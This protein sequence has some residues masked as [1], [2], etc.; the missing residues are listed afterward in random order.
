MMVIEC[1]S[2]F[3][4][5]FKMRVF[6]VRVKISRFSQTLYRN[7]TMYVFFFHSIFPTRTPFQVFTGRPHRLGVGAFDPNTPHYSCIHP[8][9]ALARVS[10]GVG[11]PHAARENPHQ[12]QRAEES[13]LSMFYKKQAQVILPRLPA[14]HH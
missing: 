6:H 9:F 13:N 7:I 14:K 2:V 5:G 12:E 1:V 11:K 8:G 3:N 10:C 4:L